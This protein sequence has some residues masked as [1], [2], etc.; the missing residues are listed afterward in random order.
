MPSSIIA[1]DVGGTSIKSGIVQ[2]GGVVRG[3]TS[4]TPIDS[5]GAADPILDTLARIITRH[6]DTARAA[7]MR[8]VAM[9]V[10]G[11]FEYDAGVSR[12]RGLGKFEALF[13]LNVR[14]ALQSRTRLTV[15]FAFRNDAEAAIVG[16]ARYGAGK[17]HRRL[18]GVTLGTGMGSAFVADGRCV[19]DGKDV[20]PGGELYGQPVAGARA[21]DWFSKRGLERRLQDAGLAPDIPAAADAARAGDARAVGVFESFGSELGAFLGPHLRAFG[22]GVLLVLGGIARSFDLFGPSLREHVP[23]P[24][25]TGARPEEAA[26]LG[27]ADLLLGDESSGDSE[28][29]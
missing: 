4:S 11:P 27:A 3:G 21:D 13:G 8:G 25:L 20:P 1:L 2:P 19:R 17:A 14:D 18:L 26:L 23:L 22:A 24:V 5:R 29:E 9:G 7:E 10:P 6:A 12:I 28:R 15:P 16:E